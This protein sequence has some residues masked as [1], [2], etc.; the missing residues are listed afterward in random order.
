MLGFYKKKKIDQR[1]ILL[2]M[3][4]NDDKRILD[5]GCA[6]GS[7]G[8]KLVKNGKEV[9][10]LEKDEDLCRQAKAVL[11]QAIHVDAQESSLPFPKGYFDAI[12][13]ADVLEHIVDPLMLLKQHRKYLRT[14]GTIIVSL[15]NIRYYK[16]MNQVFLKGV[17][18]YMDAGILD[19][20]HV[21]FFTFINMKELL[22]QAGYEILD[23][24]RNIIASSFYKVLNALCFSLNRELLTYQYYFKARKVEGPVMVIPRNKIKF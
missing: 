12:M 18:D 13:Y 16:V 6:S 1:E 24:K 9:I 21:R 23:I 5:V 22:A 15:P 10:G 2:G 4:S 3:F 7:L 11:T 19:R 8:G 14:G 20:T 17:W